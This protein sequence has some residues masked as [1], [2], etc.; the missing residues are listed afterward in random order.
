MWRLIR[1]ER[2]SSVKVGGRRRVAA[3]ALRGVVRAAGRVTRAVDV[4]PLTLDDSLFELAGK[5]S[6]DGTV[7]GSSDKHAYLGGKR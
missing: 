7:P 4:A 1:R 6:S 5:F 3:S 2:L